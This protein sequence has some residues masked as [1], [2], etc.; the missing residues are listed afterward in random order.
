[1][2]TGENNQPRQDDGSKQAETSVL[3]T[4]STESNSRN[5]QASDE[6]YR[7]FK[8]V[9]GLVDTIDEALWLYTCKVAKKIW[10]FVVHKPTFTDWVVAVAT[11]VIALATWKTY[12]EVVQGGQQTERIIA[13]SNEIKDVLVKAN[14]QN[15]SGFEQTLSQGRDAM[16]ASN[17][18][19]KAAL[20]AAIGQYRLDQ[21]AW[22]TVEVNEKTGNF[23]VAMRNTGKTP[24]VDVTEVTAFTA[25]KR[26]GPPDVDLS[27]NS[28]SPIPILKN[29]SPEI[30]EHL[31]EE[32]FVRDHP[33]TGYVIAPGD[34][35]IGSD[36]QGKFMQI[37]GFD[38][39]DPRTRAYIQG[40]VTYDDI[41]G[42][43]HETTYCYWFAP[44][45]DF[46]MCNDH[47]KMN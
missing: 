31:R 37:F 5:P 3:L 35:Q 33:P 15:Q 12:Q 7:G 41:F 2:D 6:G 25:S 32:G 11:V 9:L 34:T 16:D 29:A 4:Q 24:A 13:A 19:A 20:D 22:I 47:N 14:N 44:P 36:Y 38:T 45:S 26:F 39:N 8:Q 18:Q 46:V 17:R 43:H 27:E 42:G 40:K 23:A 10:H 1:M 30:L 28:S 21:R